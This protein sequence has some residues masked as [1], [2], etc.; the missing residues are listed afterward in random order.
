MHEKKKR[1]FYQ[2][3]KVRLYQQQIRATR[4]ATFLRCVLQRKYC[5]YYHP[6]LCCE[7]LLPEEVQ[8]LSTFCNKED[9]SRAGW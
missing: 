4:C 9:L 5:S 7:T 2:Q 1:A 6:N 8:A 3:L